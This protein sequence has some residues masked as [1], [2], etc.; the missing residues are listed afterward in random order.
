MGERSDLVIV[1]GIQYQK[2]YAIAHGLWT[3][4]AD[5]GH[6]TNA[7]ASNKAR[8]SGS[9]R[10]SGTQNTTP[11]VNTPVEG[12]STVPAAVVDGVVVD[13]AAPA[14]ETPATPETAPAA[15]TAAGETEGAGDGETP[16]STVITSEKAAPVKAPATKK[17]GR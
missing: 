8:T 7:P 16:A 4:P 9:A 6:P 11:P 12:G 5:K 15:P 1:D 17:A 10:Q 13:P 2:Q 14:G 3:E